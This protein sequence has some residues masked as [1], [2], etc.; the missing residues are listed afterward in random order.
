MMKMTFA[1]LLATTVGCASDVELPLDVDRG[2]EMPPTTEPDPPGSPSDPALPADGWSRTD[3]PVQGQIHDLV[4]TTDGA[5]V[6]ATPITEDLDAPP[7]FAPVTL[8]RHRADGAIEWVAYASPTD[9]FMELA[10]IDGGAVVVGIRPDLT[11]SSPAPAGLAWY[12]ADGNLTASW[13][14]SA[15]ETGDQLLAITSFRPLPDGGVFWVGVAGLS[16]SERVAGLLDAERQLQ[17]IVPLPAPAGRGV[18]GQTDVALTTD[19]SFVV[20]AASHPTEDWESPSDAYVVQL[21]PDG[22]ER[23]LT[24]FVGSGAA[25]GIRV[26][27]SGNLIVVGTFIGTMSVGELALEYEPYPPRHFVA[28]ID[29]DGQ[30][31]AVHR[32]EIPA[33]LVGDESRHRIHAMTVAGEDLVVAGD[34]FTDTL[35]QAGFITTTHRLDGTLASER[36]FALQ[37]AVETGSAVGPLA[38][39]VAS[40]GRMAAGGEFSGAV[41]FGDGVIDTGVVENGYPRALPFLSVFENSGAEVD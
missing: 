24:E 20:L 40:D 1:I 28:Q 38:V 37:K 14:P 27:S 22:G 39:D 32:M 5:I 21:G 3:F 34:Y 13:R 35:A 16:N 12:D 2:A 41:D 23:W 29:R 33:W 15:E 25:A 4:W 30:A 7:D 11:S 26:A 6:A 36:I 10:A 8:T 18:S 9:R 17:W 19:G 31:R